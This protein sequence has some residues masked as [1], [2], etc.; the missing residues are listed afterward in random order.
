MAKRETIEVV[1]LYEGVRDAL[2]V[3]HQNRKVSDCKHGSYLVRDY[4]GEPIQSFWRMARSI[5]ASGLTAHSN[6]RKCSH[7]PGLGRYSLQAA[8]E[9]LRHPAR[10][11]ATDPR[12]H[13]AIAGRKPGT[14]RFEVCCRALRG[15]PVAKAPVPPATTPAKPHCR[16]GAVGRGA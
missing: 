4:D 16:A 10:S 2:D 7:P 13:T 3:L 5:D 14:W 9:W 11:N 1:A 8:F 12:V 15:S 6:S